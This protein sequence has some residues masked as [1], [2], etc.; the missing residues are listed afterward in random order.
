MLT[1][2]SRLRI[3][4]ILTRTSIENHRTL[5]ERIY[6]N[7]NATKSKSLCSWLRQVSRIQRNKPVY[8]PIDE[9]LNEL[10]LSSDEHHLTKI[11]IDRL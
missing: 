9:L 8:N 2:T 4:E 10:A 7:K 1:T 5:E 3:L 6:I 11:Q